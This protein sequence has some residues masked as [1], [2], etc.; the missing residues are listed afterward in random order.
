VLKKNWDEALARRYGQLESSDFKAQMKQAE[1][2]TD[3]RPE[4][5]AAWYSFGLLRAHEQDYAGAQQAL[6]KSQRLRA[7]NLTARALSD[8]FEH[9]GDYKA[10][11][12]ELRKAL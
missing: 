12:Q 3:Q 8:L 5:P 2:W 11:L 1:R 7:H 4:S 6:E 10:A 9:Q